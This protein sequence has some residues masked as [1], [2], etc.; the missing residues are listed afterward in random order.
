MTRVSGGPWTRLCARARSASIAST[1][2]AGL[3]AVALFFLVIAPSGSADPAG[4][5]FVYMSGNQDIARR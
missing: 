5:R 3:F 4:G 2:A 1:A